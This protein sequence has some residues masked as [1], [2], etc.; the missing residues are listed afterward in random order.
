MEKKSCEDVVRR[1]TETN[2]IVDKWK[3]KI[4]TERAES[5]MK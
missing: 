1:V 5:S 2:R 4:I 3:G